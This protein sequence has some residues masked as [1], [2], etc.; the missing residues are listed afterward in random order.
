MFGGKNVKIVL[1]KS[2]TSCTGKA[3]AAAAGI[4]TEGVWY[5]HHWGDELEKPG[6]LF[7][8]RGLCNQPDAVGTSEKE[9]G[10]NLYRGIVY[11]VKSSPFNLIKL[12][13]KLKLGKKIDIKKV[14]DDLK[15]QIKIEN[16]ESI[17]YIRG[18]KIEEEKLQSSEN[19]MVV[20]KVAKKADNSKLYTFGESLINE[21]LKEHNV[22]V[23]GRD[24]L[25]IYPKL[26]YHFFI[27]ADLDTRVERKL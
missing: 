13:I 22:I 2:G 9:S 18:K 6:K 15:I 8:N 7:W 26:D 11:A 16:N 5:L 1:F 17:V 14:M 19:S 12:G 4:Q 27:T 23:S 24:L 20:S 10:G 21:Y 3:D 25:K